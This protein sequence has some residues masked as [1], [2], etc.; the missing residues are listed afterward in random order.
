MKNIFF[1][2][3]ATLLI[4][5][6]SYASEIQ[7]LTHSVQGETF[8]DESGRLR[9]IKHAGKRAFYVE[10][11]RE[12]MILMNHPNNIED[13][14]F[15]RGLMMIEEQGNRALFNV[16]RIPER[17]NKVKW[18]GPLYREIDY[19]YEM[20]NA[21]TGIT[22][23]EDA[24]KVEKICVMNGGV[25]ESILNKNNF[26][27][28]FKNHSYTGCFKM[29]KYGRVNLT[30]SSSETVSEKLEQAKISK[31]QIQQTPVV[32]IESSGYVAFSKTIS[33]EIIQQW[34]NAFE[35]IKTSGKYQQLF[36]AYYLPKGE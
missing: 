16:S 29:L 14:P 35:Q 6:N 17:E 4:S 11:V 21:P 18:V 7:F 19:F 22:T 32:L 12:M 34:Q 23:L 15:K 24:K 9:G 36:N 5:G 13:V 20:K 33:D 25:H 27:N 26:D 28:L 31:D 30:P 3:V 10:I 2:M 8:I 1:L